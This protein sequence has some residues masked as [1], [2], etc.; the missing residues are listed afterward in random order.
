M[1]RP[2]TGNFRIALLKMLRG[3]SMAFDISTTIRLLI[4]IRICAILP[5]VKH[6]LIH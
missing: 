5:S 1:T 4:I 6:L 3:F 2:M